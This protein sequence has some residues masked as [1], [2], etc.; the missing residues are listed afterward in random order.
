MWDAKSVIPE[1]AM[2]SSF[3]VYS[4]WMEAK[5]HQMSSGNAGTSGSKGVDI[6]WKVPE[7]D[8]FKVHVDASDLQYW[9]GYA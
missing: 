4:D 6:K 2:D 8:V 7:T 1:F 5:K 3:R 9:N